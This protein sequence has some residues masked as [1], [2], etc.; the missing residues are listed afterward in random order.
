MN[1][2]FIFNS[3]NNIQGLINEDEK[4]NANKY[5][6]VFSELVRQNM[7]NINAGEISLESELNL[8]RNYLFL[9]KLR[10]KNKLSYEINVHEDVEI[11]DIIIPPLT[12]QPI[13]ENAVKHGIFPLN[14]T[15]GHISINVIERNNI[16]KIAI[17][18]NGIGYSNSIKGKGNNM[19]LNSIHERFKQLSHLLEKD[20]EF[21]IEDDITQGKISGTIATITI[22]EN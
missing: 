16:V 3:L 8:V 4:E 22:H 19:A 13:V 1:P 20:M 7:H 17:I 18:D 15:D 2:H 14:K 5:L 12:I 21:S 6:K 11:N 10:F 9:E